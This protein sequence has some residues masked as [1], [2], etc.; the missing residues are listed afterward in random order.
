MKMEHTECSETSAYKIQRPENYPEESIQYGILSC[1]MKNAWKM[2]LTS[3]TISHSYTDHFAKCNTAVCVWP[4]S[5]VGRAT[6]Y[7]LDGPG[8]ESRWRERDFPPFQTGPGAHPASCTMGTGSFPG[9]KCGR[10]V[11]LTTHPLLAPRSWKGRAI[12][13]PPLRA[14]IRP[15]T[16]LLYKRT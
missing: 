16:G 4:G 5:S 9:V 11:L 14:T 13:L 6:D 1:L 12:S 2:K 8:N 10:G 3:A 15:V 7:G